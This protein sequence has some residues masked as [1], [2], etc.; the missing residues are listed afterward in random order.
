[1]TRILSLA[2]LVG[3]VG[4]SPSVDQKSAVS[5]MGAALNGTGQA[6]SKLMVNTTQT[7]ASYDGDV[8]NPAG[9]GTAHVSGSASQSGTGSSATFDIAFSHWLDTAS[10]ITIDGSL[11]ESATFT[12]TS[13]LVGDAH[14]SGMLHAT[15]AVTAD[16]DFALTVSYTQTAVQV[17]GSIGGNTINVNASAH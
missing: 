10:N 4:C 16:V 17:T 7:S 9:T 5:I 12:T 15:G 6:Q 8:T 3:L 14:L 1:M 11:H 2:C 13:P